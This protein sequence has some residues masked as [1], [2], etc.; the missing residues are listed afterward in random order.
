M[1]PDSVS[2]DLDNCFG[3]RQEHSGIPLTIHPVV[4]GAVGKVILGGNRAQRVFEHILGLW[5]SPV[6]G[7]EEG[8]SPTQSEKGISKEVGPI[9][10]HV[11]ARGNILMRNDEAG[12]GSP[13]GL[14]QA[15][16]QVQRAHAGGAT[17]PSKVAVQRGWLHFEMVHDHA[18]REFDGICEDMP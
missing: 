3:G 8:S 17:H 11:E 16:P 12:C 15:R 10:S 1:S 18:W 7:S 5:E 2:R 14:K 9:G 6:V 4:H 13:K